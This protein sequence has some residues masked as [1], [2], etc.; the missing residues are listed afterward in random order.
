MA[1]SRAQ[2]YV[3]QRQ[4]TYAMLLEVLEDGRLSVDVHRPQGNPRGVGLTSAIPAPQFLRTINVRLDP[5]SD[6]AYQVGSITDDAD[7]RLGDLWRYHDITGSER[8][9]KVERVVPNEVGSSVYLN[10]YRKT[11]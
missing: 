2:A 3:D 1:H 4:Q 10:A 8:W 5:A 11:G 9:L 6:V 7:C